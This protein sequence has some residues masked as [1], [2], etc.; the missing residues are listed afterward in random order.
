MMPRKQTYINFSP[1]PARIQRVEV[2]KT[3]TRV[4][5]PFGTPA[6]SRRRVTFGNRLSPEIFDY[7]KPPDTPIRKGST[8]MK[9]SNERKS[10]LKETPMRAPLNAVREE[11]MHRENPPK[12][13]LGPPP[14][15]DLGNS[16]KEKEEFKDMPELI[17]AEEENPN[18]SLISEPGNFSFDE[19]KFS[20]EEDEPDEP[21]K[22]PSIEQVP[23]P[24]NNQT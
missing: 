12:L 11:S 8:P 4:T 6:S 1:A 5:K 7:R 16:E 2:M 20:D 15:L 10:I 3:P 22:T 18:A 13:D 14:K 19:F 17:P 21:K 9:K 23:N 24:Q